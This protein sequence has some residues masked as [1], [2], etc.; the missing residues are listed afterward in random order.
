M[1]FPKSLLALCL[2]ALPL[3]PAIAQTQEADPNFDASVAHPAY[4][5][6]GPVVAIDAAHRN[7]HTANGRYAPFAQLLRN[8][9][10]RIVSSDQPF[11]AEALAGT[12]VLVIANALGP[13]PQAPR[14]D[15]F[16]DAECDAVGAWV[17]GGGSLL[18]VAD[19]APFGSAAQRLAAR[20]SVTMG[21]GWVFQGGA[22]PNSVTTQITYSREN[23]RLGDHPI[24]RGRSPDEAIG[25]VRAFTGQ[26]LRLD[27]AA[28]AS[29]DGVPLMTLGP[30]AH[31]APD[32]NALN[33][34][35][36]AI[37]SG[38]DPSSVAPSVAGRLQGLAMSFG[39]G[40]VVILAEAG[41]LTAQVATLPNV[42][43]PLRF[44]M[45]VSGTDNRQFVLNVLHWLSGALN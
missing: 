4:P 44:G 2:A 12:R 37:A 5:E 7:F 22:Q 42:P 13:D 28:M 29:P 16:T 41:M 1:A 19:H 36:Q 40:R 27:S 11:T 24:L 10:Y 35:A 17:R 9:G 23:G 3:G 45:N 21:E 14:G 31:E 26:S 30:D 38:A 43:E 34:G 20:F 18:L 8:D 6:R 39:A 33:A 15:A 25:S 32:Q